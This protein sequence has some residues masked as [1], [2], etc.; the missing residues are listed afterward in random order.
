MFEALTASALADLGF[1][2]S[3]ALA[4]LALEGLCF[5][6]G[7]P[8]IQPLVAKTRTL[9]PRVASFHNAPKDPWTWGAKA[10]GGP[11]LGGLGFRDRKNH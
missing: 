3:R 2:L 11:G 8:F 4:S 10:L 5:P 6:V 7:V 1:A 9:M